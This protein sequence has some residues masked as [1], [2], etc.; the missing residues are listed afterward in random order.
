[1][2]KAIGILCYPSV[3]GSGVVATE[4]GMKLADRGHD[5]H[6]ITSS[7]PFRLT[8]YR[9]NITVHLV[10]VNQYSVFKYPPYDITLASKVA[11]VIDLFDLDIIHAHYAVPH[12]VCAE[13]GRNMAKKKGV[14]VVTTLHG[15]DIT[16]IGQDLEM[17]PAIRYGIESSDAV[18][19]VSESL[20]LETNITLNGQYAIE[21]IPNSIDESMYYPMRDERLKRHYG[22]EP[23]EIV[24]IHISNFRPVKRI[25]DTIAAFAIAS[26]DRAMRL[27]LVGDGP[28]MGQTRRRAKELGIYDKIIFAGKQEHVAQLLA[29][30]DIHLL[31]SEKEAFG[32][33]VLEAMAVGVPSVV[34]SAGGLPEVIQDGKTGFIVPT[35]DVKTA[36]DRIGKLADDAALR[37][38]LAEEG[39]RD[40]RRRFDS[41]QVV[42]AYELLYERVCAQYENA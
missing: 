4:L 17:Q 25:D 18:T 11:E 2:K 37:E 23:D 15:T 40:T 7:I 26:K 34:S 33:V 14:G 30:S 6:F 16:V 3:G 28:E 21:V 35:Y 38:E 36:A 20:A 8:E 10:E 22:I 5:V 42:R 24:V 29:I 9:P 41:N 1:M 39:I 12:A 32:L 13:L 19:A 31:L 27:L